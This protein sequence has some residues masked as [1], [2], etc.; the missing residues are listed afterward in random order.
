MSPWIRVSGE[1]IMAQELRARVKFEDIYSKVS[2]VI[3]AERPSFWKWLIY[4][5]GHMILCSSVLYYHKLIFD[6]FY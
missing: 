2:G 6:W 3:S 5:K 4:F 1:N